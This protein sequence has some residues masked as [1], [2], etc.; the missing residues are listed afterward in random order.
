MNKHFERQ[1][2]FFSIPYTRPW[3]HFL[4]FFQRALPR[5]DHE[6]TSQ[7][8][9]EFHASRAR[10]GHLRRDVYRKISRK[11]TNKTAY[12]HILH[13]RRVHSG[14]DNCSKILLRFRHFVLENERG[15]RY[16]SL[17]APTVQKFHQLGQI[18]FCEIMRAHSGVEF[19][20][21]KINGIGAVLYCCLCAFPIS[22]RCEQFGDRMCRHLLRDRGFSLGNPALFAIQHLLQLS[23][24]ASR[25]KDS[26]LQTQIT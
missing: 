14:C 26:S 3:M 22:R 8:P 12:P 18:R 5:E 6:V 4:D 20:E 16:I 1:R 25:H 13:N 19:V 17:Y 21:A 9:G 24:N 7:L 15:E 23:F 11:L 10:N 2:E